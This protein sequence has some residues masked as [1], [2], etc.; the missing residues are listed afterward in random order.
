MQRTDAQIRGHRR[1]EVSDYEARL[2]KWKSFWH[3]AYRIFTASLSDFWAM[4]LTPKMRC[5][6]PSSPLTST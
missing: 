4:C 1:L 5:R 3:T 2:E 6:M